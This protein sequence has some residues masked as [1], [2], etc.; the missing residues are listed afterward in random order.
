MPVD[1]VSVK[2]SVENCTRFSRHSI[3]ILFILTHF[4]ITSSLPSTDIIG[5]IYQNSSIRIWLHSYPMCCLSSCTCMFG[6]TMNFTIFLKLRSVAF[7]KI[8]VAHQVPPNLLSIQTCT[9]SRST[10]EFCIL[11]HGPY[12]GYF[13]P[14]S[15]LCAYI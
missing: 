7:V 12:L 5:H 10:F 3:I 13:I 8:T 14:S 4:D 11:C 2:K 9:I 6:I 15:S 1:T